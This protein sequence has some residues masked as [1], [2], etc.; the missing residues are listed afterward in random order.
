MVR[1][2]SFAC[3]SFLVASLAYAEDLD[4]SAAPATTLQ[5]PLP[6]TELEPTIA[7]AVS[8]RIVRP[9]ANDALCPPDTEC[10][11]GQGFAFGV[12]LERRWESGPSVGFRYDAWFVDANT[13]YELG[14]LQAVQAF[15]RYAFVGGDAFSPYL[16]GSIGGAAFGDSFGIE[17][18]GLIV[19]AGFG[20]ELELGSTTSLT[21][22]VPTSFLLLSEFQ[23]GVDAATRAS[24][25]I[26]IALAL[27]VGFR[28]S[29]IPSM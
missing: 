19:E 6:P 18:V 8:T 21:C 5:P 1:A 12:A 25:G 2:Y 13:V 7:A 27:Q 4:E 24:G 26:D 15:G 29:Q 23:T 20:V 10:I 17:T 28:F 9:I 14:V 16:F 11:F 3:A 22:S